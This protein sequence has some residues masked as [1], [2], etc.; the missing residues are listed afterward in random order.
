M[1]KQWVREDDIPGYCE[2]RV[3]A[4]RT[5]EASA[6][7]DRFV[8]DDVRTL[9]VRYGANGERLRTFRESVKEF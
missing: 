5:S 9:E 7:E 2:E 8:A 6:G 4:M 3:Q 1:R